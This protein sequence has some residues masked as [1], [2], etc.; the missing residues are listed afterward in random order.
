MAAGL[1]RD[2][3]EIRARVA[4]LFDKV[5]LRPDQIDVVVPPQISKQFIG[6]LPAAI[7]I[8]ADRAGR[9]PVRA[10]LRPL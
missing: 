5:G 4:A 10:V 7:G 1:G 2:A 3:D 6:G 9:R 8:G